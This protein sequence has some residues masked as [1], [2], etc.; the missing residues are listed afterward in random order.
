M[1]Y[2]SDH[3]QIWWPGPTWEGHNKAGPKSPTGA[4]TCKEGTGNCWFIDSTNSNS[5]RA[6]RVINGTSNL[7][8]AEFDSKWK[9]DET[10]LEFVELYDLNAD[11]WQMDNLHNKTS[12][13]VLHDLHEQVASYFSCSG[14]QC[15]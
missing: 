4:K 3:S 9:F 1:Q 11:P 14:S 6:L 15:P 12:A 8:Y 7:L 10:G 13:A 2:Y 5:Y